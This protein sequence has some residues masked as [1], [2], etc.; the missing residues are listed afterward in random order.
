VKAPLDAAVASAGRLRL[1][2]QSKAGQRHAGEADAELLQRLSPRDRLGHSLGQ[3]IELVVHNYPFTF[4]F[5]R[6]HVLLNSLRAI[7]R[8]T[9]GPTKLPS[10]SATLVHRSATML[11]PV[12]TLIVS[13][14]SS[15]RQPQRGQRDAS[16]ADELLQR[17]AA[18]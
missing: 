8:D 4:R 12:R 10:L 2:G 9:G 17:A 16:E 6:E 13:S 7:E 1:A 18:R 14:L 15:V 3:F 11:A 5:V